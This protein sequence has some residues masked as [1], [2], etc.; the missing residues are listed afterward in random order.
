MATKI[1]VT[2]GVMG[3]KGRAEETDALWIQFGKWIKGHRKQANLN[4]KQ[5]AELLDIHPVHLS[6]IET[7]TTGTSR[8]IV[9]ALARVLR[10]DMREALNKAGMDQPGEALNTLEQELLKYFNKLPVTQQLD[11][12][13]LAEAMWRRHGREIE[14]KVVRKR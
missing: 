1:P 3:R 5:V 8:E 11:L 7:G 12:L 10:L 9:S 6:R 14:E 13:A 4:Q 2:S